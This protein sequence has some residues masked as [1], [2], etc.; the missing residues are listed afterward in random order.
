MCNQFR[1]RSQMTQNADVDQVEDY[2]T[3]QKQNEKKIRDLLEVR[4]KW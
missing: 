2:S 4:G 1:K 3:K